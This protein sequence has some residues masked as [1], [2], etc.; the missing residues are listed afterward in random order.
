MSYP[1]I[2]YLGFPGHIKV[3]C[4]SRADVSTTITDDTVETT[5]LYRDHISVAI[6]DETVEATVRS[7]TVSTA[8]TDETVTAEVDDCSE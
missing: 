6:T 1:A 7:D 5:I 8:V 2:P 4:T 3:T